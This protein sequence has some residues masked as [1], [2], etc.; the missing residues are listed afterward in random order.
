MALCAAPAYARTRPAP[1]LPE[2]TPAATPAQTQTG[3]GPDGL[4]PNSFYLEADIVSQ[5]NKSQVAS[6]EGH[7]EVR[8]RGRTVRA[9][10]LTYDKTTQVVTAKGDVVVINTDGT[11]EF[12]KELTL[13]KDLSAGVAL[14][15]SARLRDNVKI[16]SDTL[17]RR[18]S[19]VT[20]LNEAIYTPCDIC[21][22]N[23]QSKNPTWSIQA[24]RVVEDKAKHLIYF[25]HAVIKVM[26]VPVFYT[27]VFWSADAESTSR[28]GLLA[29]EMQ[30]SNRR[31]FSFEQPYLLAISPSQDLTISPIVSTKIDPFLNLDWRARFNSGEID[32]RV[33]YTYEYAFDN[34]G[35][36]VP[37][38]AVTS[39]SYILANGAFTL[40]N[41]WDWGFSAERA[42]DDL[43]FDRYDIRGVYDDRG[44]FETDSRRLLSQVYAV[45]QDQN[46]YLSISALDFQGLRVDDVNKG[47][48]V[49]APLIE[50]RYEPDGPIL[51]GRLILI[52]SAVVLGR[53][54]QVDDPTL[55]GMDSRRAT[56]EAD[57]RRAFTLRDGIRI[58]PFGALRGD[59]YNVTNATTSATTPTGTPSI[60]AGRFLPEAGV[61]VSYPLIRQD[62]GA[63][64]ILEPLAEG[65]ISP[66]AKANPDIP[67]EDSVDFLFDDTNLFDPNRAPG[68]DV[69]DSG[70][71]L[72]LG[73][74][75]TINWGD[76]LQ[77]RALIGRSFRSSPDLTL[78]PTSGY[79]GTASN[80]IFSASVTP[81]KGL[82]IYDRTELDN[83][84][85][86]LRR[87]E[88]GANFVLSFLQ[89]YVR[90]LHDNSDP[91][92]VLHDVEGAVNLNVTRNWGVVFY[93]T[94][95]LKDDA[96]SRRDVGVF[97]QNDCARVE[98]VYH[99]EA[100][101]AEL[102]GPSHSVQL[103]LTLATLGQQGYR[104]DDGR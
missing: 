24:Q 92:N 46:S 64:V 9:Q 85:F 26:G 21:A 4:E 66:R 54:V 62:G 53:D 12:A 32:A 5:D 100:G 40:N 67:N 84:N 56:G 91:A 51:G 61:D 78:P 22:K 31:G 34:N 89:G 87:E 101:F 17:I 93:G 36:R 37:G 33:G 103:R 3:P 83:A 55:P 7:V 79:S 8:Y 14:G 11:A 6:A 38:S 98:V 35:Q 19:D 102:G 28:S 82:S 69:Y 52:G 63:S 71:R 95:D 96:W 77:A 58:E 104:D 81:V 68:F 59:V 57:W 20:E 86:A 16:A 1:P 80:W 27:P 75:A 97:F 47:M 50:G 13:D 39:R 23:G 70:A 65:I 99:Y 2:P 15:F 72:N 42:T 25:H 88:V 76:G 41:E 29:P 90:Y 60:T 44:L 43:L 45:R 49:V 74:R 18:S 30:V 94:R 48:P 73:G 10:S